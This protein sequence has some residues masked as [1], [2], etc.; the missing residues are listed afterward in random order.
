[1]L[2]NTYK[3]NQHRRE[4]SKE[5]SYNRLFITYKKNAKQKGREFTLEFLEFYKLIKSN[6]HY[7]GRKPSK[8]FKDKCYVTGKKYY[9]FCYNGIDR[10]D[11]SIGYILSNSVP[12]CSECNSMKSNMNVKKFKNHV[13]KIFKFR[14]GGK[15]VGFRKKDKI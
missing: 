13:S 3:S 4:K 6:C 9:Q 11:N 10:V 1:M 8:T 14:F 15:N 5:S 12:C 2:G 7:C